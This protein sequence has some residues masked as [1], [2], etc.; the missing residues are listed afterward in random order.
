MNEFLILFILKIKSS[1]IYEIKKSINEN[2]SPF[3]EVSIGAVIPALNRLTAAGCVT[4]EKETTEGGLRRTIYTITEKG[5]EEIDKYI[6][7]EIDCAPQLLR[8]ETEVLMSLLD[9]ENLSD[10][11]K[12]LLIQKIE[13]ALNENIKIIA[14]QIK[15]GK[16]NAEYLNMEL[17]YQEAKIR[18]LKDLKEQSAEL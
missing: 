8:R 11:Q 16:M 9:N 14:N 2:F 17:V 1:N 7:K 6:E 10:A 18:L 15:F 5:A 13:N 3:L 4:S 12:F